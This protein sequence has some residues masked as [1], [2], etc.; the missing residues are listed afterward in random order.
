LMIRF[1]NWI[2]SKN[3]ERR[4]DEVNEAK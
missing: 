4:D 1:V 3:L 2:T